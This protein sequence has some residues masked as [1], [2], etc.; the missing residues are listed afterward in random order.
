VALHRR[1]VE[2]AGEEARQH[3]TTAAGRV[4]GALAQP[5]GIRRPHA[6]T[7]QGSRGWGRALRFALMSGS[8]SSKITKRKATKSGAII[9]AKE[10]AGAVG[11]AAGA[12]G[13]ALLHLGAPAAAALVA[14]L[15]A[16][17]PAGVAMVTEAAARRMR[18]RG[19][20]FWETIV[21]TWARDDGMTREK[22]AALLEARKDDADVS[23]AIWRAVRALMDAPTDAAAVPLGVLAAEYARN[24]RAADTFFRGTVRLLS[25]LT[26]S[27]VADLSGLLGWV[28]S[29]TCRSRVTVLANDLEEHKRPPEVVQGVLRPATTYERVLWYVQ[30]RRDDPDRPGEPDN[31]AQDAWIRFAIPPQDAGRLFTL[32]KASGLGAEPSMGVF[33]PAIL[34]ELQRATVERLDRILRASSRP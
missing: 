23:D 20:R 32:L 14:A 30:L 17:F 1:Q 34:L 11:A 15:L 27:E 18:A 13:G 29:S 5:E 3:L 8:K 22:V 25:E 9:T 19:D 6:P 24:A 26:E 4:L 33:G 21:D 12:A 2:P 28:L 10:A 16:L 7:L 31:V